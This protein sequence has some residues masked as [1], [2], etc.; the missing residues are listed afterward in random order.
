[1][2]W[3]IKWLKEMIDEEEFEVW[4]RYFRRHPFDPVSLHQIPTAQL[5]AM[6][7]GAHSAQGSATPR[8]SDFLP[9]IREE[10]DADIE[11]KLAEGNW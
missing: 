1:M 2:G 9:G 10:S 4:C 6:Y 3:P 7:A 11:R 8:P 5:C